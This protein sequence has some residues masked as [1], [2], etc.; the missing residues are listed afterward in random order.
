MEVWNKFEMATIV[1]SMSDLLMLHYSHVK[2]DYET[3]VKWS[4]DDCHGFPPTG[5]TPTCP[6]WELKNA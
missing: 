4:R 3:P 2:F 1:S 5:Y 6:P